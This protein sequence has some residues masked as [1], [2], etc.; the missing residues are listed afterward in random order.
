MSPDD[1]TVAANRQAQR[2]LYGDT[3]EA[4]ITALTQHYGV[5]QRRLARALGISAPMLSQL[6]SARRVKMGNTLAYERMVA[7]ADRTGEVTDPDAAERI[8][9]EVAAS[10]AVTTMQMR[11]QPG[12][13]RRSAETA[14]LN[15]VDSA[16]LRAARDHLAGAGVAPSVVALI[17]RAL[18]NAPR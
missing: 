16:Q 11:T 4:R 15:A 3:L 13:V 10:D 12:Q 6:I 14:L 2:D 8:L 17:D 1:A 18:G 5:S 7:L 9:Q